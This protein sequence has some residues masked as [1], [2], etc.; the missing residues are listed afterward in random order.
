MASFE[1]KASELADRLIRGGDYPDRS[2]L[3]LGDVQAEIN[4]F[5]FDLA[6]VGS[7]PLSTQ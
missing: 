1:G 3:Y 6:V 7:R 5:Q 2:G 4:D